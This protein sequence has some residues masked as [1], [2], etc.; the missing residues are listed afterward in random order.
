MNSMTLKK[1]IESEVRSVLAEDYMR[2][3]TDFA[4]SQVASEASESLKRHLRRHIQQVAQDPVRQR[5][6]L[7]AASIVLKELE[8]EMKELLEDKLAKFVRSV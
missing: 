7:A 2:G 4:L 1:L 8:V 6:M 5:D 3:I